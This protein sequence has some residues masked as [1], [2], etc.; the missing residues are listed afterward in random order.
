MIDQKM[1]VA[2]EKSNLVLEHINF[3]ENDKLISTSKIIHA[4]KSITKTQIGIRYIPFSKLNIEENYGAMM[5]VVK[6]N[7]EE[8]A[9]IFINSD[10]DSEYQRFSLVHELGHLITGRHNL[11]HDGFVISTHIDQNVFSIEEK[12]YIS[13]S[14]LLNE[15]IANVF[16]LRTLIPFKSLMSRLDDSSDLKKIANSFG[17]TKEAIISRIALGE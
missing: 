12:D 7:G 15:Q 13:N 14:Y 4:V 6:K 9:E 2:V 5:R 8:I 11:D 1:N 17:V 10:N 3:S 16:A